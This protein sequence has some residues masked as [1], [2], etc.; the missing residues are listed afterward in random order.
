MHVC[1]CVCIY[2]WVYLCIYVHFFFLREKRLSIKS[3]QDPV[4]VFQSLP[5]ISFVNGSRGEENRH[6]IKSSFN[7]CLSFESTC[8]L[9]ATCG[10]LRTAPSTQFGKI[11]FVTDS[12]LWIKAYQKKKTKGMI[13]M[14]F[15]LS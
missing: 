12:A 8:P 4:Q 10:R 9:A 1:I 13:I 3:G 5:T 2:V 14:Q 15:E 11:A 6:F 7:V